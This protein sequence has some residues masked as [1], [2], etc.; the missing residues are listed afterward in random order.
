MMRFT[1]DLAEGGFPDR[2]LINNATV[3][4]A[5]ILAALLTWT[6]F[7]CV[8]NLGEQKRIRDDIADLGKRVKGGT[9][10][11]SESE[12]ALMRAEIRFFNDVIERRAF[13]WLALLEQVENATPEGI[14]ISSLAPDRKTGIVK[15]EGLAGNFRSVRTFLEIL[16]DHGIFSDV[17]LVSHEKK[18]LWEQAKGV[19]FVVTFRVR[20]A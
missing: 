9:P 13:G 14:W 10:Q 19:R 12:Y 5:L 6:T 17:S 4:L 20:S 2:R 16:Q 15:V 11:A 3:A 7:R 8:A 1:I 18:S